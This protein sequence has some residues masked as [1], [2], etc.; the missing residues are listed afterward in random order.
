VR[1]WPPAVGGCLAYVRYRGGRPQRKA[2]RKTKNTKAEKKNGKAEIE[3]TKNK[4]RKVV[5]GYVVGCVVGWLVTAN[6]QGSDRRR[7]EG[8]MLGYV[9]VEL[10]GHGGAEVFVQVEE[11][12]IVPRLEEMGFERSCRDTENVYVRKYDHAGL[13]CAKCVT[14]LV[15]LGFLRN[16]DLEFIPA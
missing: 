7:K 16:Y 15:T 13:D 14:R 12:S 6:N 1:V 5:V 2:V 10:P 9:W 8:A 3:K 11:P 4:K